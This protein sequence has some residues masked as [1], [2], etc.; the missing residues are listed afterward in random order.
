MTICVHVWIVED[1][2]YEQRRWL[3]AGQHWTTSTDDRSGE[4]SV[5]HPDRHSKSFRLI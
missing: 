2:G 3:S 4:L 1:V 5:Y